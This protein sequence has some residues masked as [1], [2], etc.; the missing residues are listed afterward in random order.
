M[1]IKVLITG[2]TIDKSYNMH[3]G[4]L[5]FVDSH[6]PAMLAEGRCK[7]DYE[8]D[9]LMLK[10]SLEMTDHDRVQILSGCIQSDQSKIIVTHGTDTMVQTAQF[11]DGQVE[12]KTIVITGAM[13]PYVFDKSDSIFNL[14]SAFTAVQCLPAGVYI[15]MNGKVFKARDVVK[16]REEGVFESLL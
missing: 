13:T 2:G 15:A 5:H 1:N 12:G 16:N 3:N 10:D 11:L 7:A 8:L 14:G 9:K 6:I 4:E